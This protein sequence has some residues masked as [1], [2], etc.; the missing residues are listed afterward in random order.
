MFNMTKI[1]ATNGSGKSFY[2]N[3]LSSNDYYS[4]QERVE[5]HWLGELV[6]AFGLRGGIVTSEEFSLFQKNVN[7]KT[8]DKLTQKIPANSILPLSENVRKQ[9]AELLPD[10]SYKDIVKRTKAALRKVQAMLNDSATIQRMRRHRERL[11]DEYTHFETEE[12]A[13]GLIGKVMGKITGLFKKAEEVPEVTD[14]AALERERE[15]ELEQD[16]EQARK[17]EQKALWTVFDEA[18]KEYVKKRKEYHALHGGGEVFELTE[19]EEGYWKQQMIRQLR[20]EA[21]EALPVRMYR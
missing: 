17:Q 21:P 2:A 10:F 8:L 18:W 12:H 4:E 7:P 13:V 6:D 1:R 16:R 15:T 5:G 20:N 11:F 19:W 9:K 3:H 14:K